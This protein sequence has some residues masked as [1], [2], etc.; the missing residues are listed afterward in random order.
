MGVTMKNL[1]FRY[2]VLLTTIVVGIGCA[3]AQDS[4]FAELPYE[5]TPTERRY[6]SAEHQRAL[7]AAAKT[8]NKAERRQVLLSGRRDLEARLNRAQSG[9][10]GT[11]PSTAILQVEYAL[12]LVSLSNAAQDE[13]EA[14]RARQQAEDH[15][16]AAVRSLL[17]ANPSKKAA[18]YLVFAVLYSRG[19]EGSEFAAWLPIALERHRSA[20]GEQMRQWPLWSELLQHMDTERYDGLVDEAEFATSKEQVLRERLTAAAKLDSPRALLTAQLDFINHL[21]EFNPDSE[22]LLPIAEAA[23]PTVKAVFQASLDSARSKTTTD[24]AYSDSSY[25]YLSHG[26]GGELDNLRQVFARN[27]LPDLEEQA[28]RIL[29]DG[30][31]LAPRIETDFVE[32]VWTFNV[33]L[34]GKHRFPELYDD[35][36][37]LL[38]RFRSGCGRETEI[39]SACILRQASK[40]YS[41]LGQSAAALEFASDRVQLLE[42]ASATYTGQHLAAYADLAE[43]EWDFGT[44]AGSE[45]TLDRAQ[46]IA[47][48]HPAAV[49]SLAK[50]KMSVIGSELADAALNDQLARQR[51]AEAVTASQA[52]DNHA[53]LGKSNID[54]RLFDLFIKHMQGRFCPLCQPEFEQWLTYYFELLGDNPEENPGDISLY[55]YGLVAERLGY[56][57]EHHLREWARHYYSEFEKSISNASDLLSTARAGLSRQDDDRA[58]LELLLL[59]HQPINGEYIFTESS[60]F[61]A[62]LQEANYERKRMLGVELYSQAYE[63]NYAQFGADTEYIL[64]AVTFSLVLERLNYKPT[65]RAVLDVML[66]VISRYMFGTDAF[67]ADAAADLTR[68]MPATF[69]T[70]FSKMASFELAAGNHAEADRYLT[71][72]SSVAAGELEH[73]WNAGNVRATLAFRNMGAAL[74]QIARTRFELISSLGTDLRS[75]VTEKAFVELQLAM[76][77]ETALTILSATRRKAASSPELA[78]TL[79]QRD[80]TAQQIDNLEQILELNLLSTGGI[81]RELDNLRTVRAKLE[82][83]ISDDVKIVEGFSSLKAVELQELQEVIGGDEAVVFLHPTGQEVDAMIVSRDA[84]P[85]SWTAPLSDA[86]L[87]RR[88]VNIRKGV[89]VKRLRGALNDRSRP[90][91]KFPFADAYELY[92]ALFWPVRDK[93]KSVGKLVIIADGALQALP[94][95]VLTTSMPER[96]PVNLS[97]FRDADIDWLIEQNALAFLPSARALFAQRKNAGGARARLSFLGIG[98]P[99]LLGNG[100]NDRAADA[101]TIFSRSGLADTQILSDLAPLPETEAELRTIAGTLEADETDLLLGDEANEARVK[102]HQL[103]DYQII[104]FATHGLLAR[105]EIHGTGEPGLVLTPPETPTDR[106]D[107]LLT[108]SEIMQLELNA[109][110]VILSACDTASSDGRPRAGGL[111]GLARGFFAAGARS[112]MVTHWSIPSLP[113]VDITT[114]M[115]AAR[116]ADPNLD[117]AAALQLAQ[118]SLIS[119]TGPPHFAHPANWGAFM[120]V[121]VL[122]HH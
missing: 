16:I 70:I 53:E 98:N 38:G 83:S 91:P 97:E 39:G 51:F 107:G 1:L 121:G 52:I 7:T 61:A 111:S 96:E 68:D 67:D 119:E 71:W 56:V 69:V 42:R 60:Q 78:E 86:D 62:F 45:A 20:F 109:D 28:E 33:I 112:I 22:E 65:A 115:V 49:D 24:E 26:S 84:A 87:E 103:A 88:L 108:L 10:S 40:G 3:Q 48:Q 58:L 31:A 32:L 92:K 72:A 120:V 82:R 89:D 54:D 102:S 29:F 57:E 81:E 117:W 118:V 27:N 13:R 37:A 77:T 23:F 6:V 12:L 76:L 75:D 73:E 15:L 50:A 5:F 55:I 17:N 105:N 47:L 94:F 63:S 90:Q 34:G 43:L 59:V 104:A 113:A 93:L 80:R 110:L 74:E 35:V 9:A 25:F 4:L 44:V 64:D 95:A 18:D 106:D 99:V 8:D 11:A 101:A 21:S 2:A 100:T 114:A 122:P 41:M 46:E 14:E 79:Q 116:S 85:V 19:F 36:L 30:A 66:E